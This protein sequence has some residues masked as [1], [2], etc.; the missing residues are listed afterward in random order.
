M[1]FHVPGLAHTV[2]HPDYTSCAFTQKI[3]KLC[4][5]LSAR[6]HTVY[7]YGNAGSEVDPSE[8]KG[9][10]EWTVGD[11]PEHDWRKLG[12]PDYNAVDWKAFNDKV[13][14]YIGQTKE[15]GD[16]ILFSFGNCQASIAADHP[17]LIAVEAG[18]G[19]PGG[20]F[21]S[22]KVFESYAI[23]NAYKGLGAVADMNGGN[24]WYDTVIPNY[25]DP[26]AFMFQAEKADHLLF[27]GRA[28]QGKGLHIAQDLAQRTGHKLVM[29]GQGT[30]SF[31]NG[32]GVV[33]PKARR[34]LLSQ[35]KA[36][37]CASTYAEPFCGVQIEAFLSGTP[38]LS[39]D[40]GAFAEYNLHGHTGFRCRTM[41]EF[42]WAVEHVG[43][44]DP[45]DCRWHG[46][47]FD[48][49]KIAP[50]YEAYFQNLA[51]VH[52]GAGWYA[53]TSSAWPM[54]PQGL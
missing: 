40:F 28:G 22:Y 37:I 3:L 15:P 52:G 33:G 20:H 19:Y 45:H 9:V 1:R 30:D 24:N 54:A 29:A 47:Q 31:P 14:Q 44:I 11:P 38:V 34:M 21:A 48:M 41:G 36:V 51:Q 5:M 13:S 25:F 35:A 8:G 53:P 26:K 23:L 32:L 46:L 49:E 2:T 39:S 10:I 16:F 4:Q 18:I 27:L 6:G 7:H 42:V 43:E 17:E 12:F 50:M